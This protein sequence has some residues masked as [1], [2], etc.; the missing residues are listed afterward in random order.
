M[1]ND[2]QKFGVIDLTGNWFVT[3]SDDGNYTTG[4]KEEAHRMFIAQLE[5]WLKII[6]EYKIEYKVKA[7]Q[8]QD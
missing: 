3:L 8:I 6:K 7:F 2:K 4:T 5:E 1:K